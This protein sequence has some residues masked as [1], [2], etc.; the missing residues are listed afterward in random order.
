[1]SPVAVVSTMSKMYQML[2]KD[3]KGAASRP[4]K[5]MKPQS[6]DIDRGENIEVAKTTRLALRVAFISR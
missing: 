5:K 1:M 4:K 2:E 3:F 6:H